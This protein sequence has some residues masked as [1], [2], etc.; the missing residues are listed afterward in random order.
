[1]KKGPLIAA[2]VIALIALAGIIVGATAFPWEP[3][4]TK[5]VGQWL[6]WFGI[7]FIG[8]SL[9]VM[10]VAFIKKPGAEGEEAAEATTEPSS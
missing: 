10:I 1:M 2:G 6:F 5:N 4:N 7:I 3:N 9:I 8:Q